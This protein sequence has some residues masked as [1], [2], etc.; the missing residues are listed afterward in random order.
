[1]DKLNESVCCPLIVMLPL[2]CYQLK[3]QEVETLTP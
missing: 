3:F 1:M 2:V